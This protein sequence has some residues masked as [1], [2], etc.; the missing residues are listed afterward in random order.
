MIKLTKLTIGNFKGIKNLT[1]NFQNHVTNIYGANETGKTSVYDAFLWCLFGKDSSDRADF[2][3]RPLDKLNIPNNKIETEVEAGL[4]IDGLDVTL[5]RVF[6]PKW[7]K[8]RGAAEAE[9]KGNETV[10]F[11]NDVPLKQSDYK[12]KIEAIIDENLFKLLTNPLYFNLNLKWQDR[13]SMLIKMADSISDDT[14]L[15]SLVSAEYA[16]QVEELRKQLNA[17]KSVAEYRLEIVSKKKKIKD[18]LSF[19]PARID[20]QHRSLPTETINYTDIE[21]KIKAL[22]SEIA[23]ID[24]VIQDSNN[25]LQE[26]K[27]AMYEALNQKALLEGDLMDEKNKRGKVFNETKNGIKSKIQYTENQISTIERNINTINAEIEQ[28]KKDIENYNALRKSLREEWVA[29]N[30]KQLVINEDEFNCPACKREL[31][32]D[33]IKETRNK[34]TEQYNASKAKKLKEIEQRGAQAKEVCEKSEN[35]ILELEV[36]LLNERESIKV[37][38]DVALPNLQTDLNGLS[39][40]SISDPTEAEKE[41][42]AKI[43]SIVV[44]VFEAP[45]NTELKEKQSS[46]YQDVEWLNNQLSQRDTELKTKERISELEIQQKSL[47]AEL[48]KFEKQEYIVDKFNKE[49]IT[50]IEQSINS[51]FKLVRFKM[52][53][54]AINGGESECCETIHDGVPFSDKN[55]AGKIL[56]GI[57][58][59]NTFSAHYNINAPIFL[60][61]RESVT[62]IPDTES[63]IINLIVS[64]DDKI[65]RIG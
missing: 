9:F 57:D 30:E 6:K 63:Q 32:E 25:A 55:T 51:K 5:K 47:S 28:Y 38:K 1:I 2:N 4:D 3:I 34:L 22:K 20:E 65:L 44:P 27:K 42:Q 49:K 53:E 48:M 23:S 56:C 60:D 33:D 13:R 19:I 41:I 12:A 64:P 7:V 26:Q 62:E 17:G 29:I 8:E 50:S 45:N 16:L 61:N 11:Y 36:K 35:A 43:D 14:I 37:L 58:I 52:F 54:Q 59:I 39:D 18:E 15:L 31:P 21:N 46:L 24:A 10:Y 40:N